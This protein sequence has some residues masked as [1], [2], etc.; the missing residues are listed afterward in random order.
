MEITEDNFSYS[1]VKEWIKDY[2]H[3][4]KV[5]FAIHCDELGIDIYESNHDSKVPRLAID[6][7]K[8]WVES[9]TEHNRKAAFAAADNAAADYV[10]GKGD[11]PAFFAA[12][13]SFAA[14]S[15]V[16]AADY[17]AAEAS[18]VAFFAAD[19]G[20]ENVKSKIISW[21][22]NNDKKED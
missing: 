19:V 2:S 12:R 3:Q 11:D 22:I 20:G 4:D 14:F 6:A 13:T 16:R 18:E 15:A 7:A 21:F 1:N 17:V 10:A 5:R 8:A 9:P